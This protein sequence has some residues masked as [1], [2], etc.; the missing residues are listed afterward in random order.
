MSVSNSS[1]FHLVN[2][3]TRVVAVPT[4]LFSLGLIPTYS[5]AAGTLQDATEALGAAKLQSIAFSGTGRWYQF[6]QAPNPKSPWPPFDVSSYSATINYDHPAARVQITRKQVVEAGR[7]RPA[8]VEQKPDQYVSGNTAWNL[9]AAPGSATP[10]VQP[11]PAQ[12]EERVTE[13]WTTPQGFLKAA[14]ANNATSQAH[15]GGT[16]LTFTAGKNRYVGII[17]AKNQVERVQ[18]WIDNPVLGDTEIDYTYSDYKDFNGISFPAQIA[19]KQGGY[20]VL[21]LKISSVT[22]NP[23]V[24]IEVPADA[25]NVPAITVTS[26]ELAP[27]VY[28]LKGGT[29]HSVLIDQKDHL[30]LVE[31]PLNEARSEAVIAKSKELVPNKPI[32]YL[33]NTHHHFDHSGGVRTFVDEGATIVTH[34]D[35][36]P[37]FQ[38]IWS[39]KHTINPDRLANSKKS[40]KFAA[41]SDKHVL[42]DGQRVIEVHSIK[43]SGHND[44]F[45]LIYLPAE[46]ILIEA[47]AYTPL[48]AGVPAP[49]SINPYSANLYD[50]IKRLKLNVDK[51]AA[52]HGPQVVKLADLEAFIGK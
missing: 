2:W 51:I 44:A 27:G 25:A 5:M 8:P 30:V 46:K 10:T 42:T 21:D 49:A 20:P 9:A 15:N 6:G 29:H 48:A 40:A 24:Q 47:D 26:E 17:N 18:T 12:V 1:Y 52:L 45:A 41:F 31:G 50:N 16:K 14:A 23:A 7:D 39:N 11:Q 32:R 43:H 4:I 35:N 22:V 3:R 13:I 28:Y 37:Y 36:K 38:K 33:V 19:R 34:Q